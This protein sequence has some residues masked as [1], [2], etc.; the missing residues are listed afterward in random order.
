V[1]SLIGRRGSCRA[2]RRGR[3][4]GV[5]AAAVQ[6]I[7]AASLTLALTA[8]SDPLEFADWTF[9][10][11]EG[12]RVIGYAATPDDERTERIDLVEDLVLGLDDSDPEQRFY[13]LRDVDADGDGNLW[14]LDGGNSR[15]QVFDRDGAFV[16]TV[17]REGQGPG[18]LESP[19]WLT[20]AGEHV[21]VRS[22]QSRISVFSAL[23]GSHVG[24]ATVSESGFSLSTLTGRSDGTFYAGTTEFDRSGDT[25]LS[26]GEVPAELIVARFNQDAG[27]LNEVVRLPSVVIFVSSAAEKRPAGVARPFASFA[28]A[29]TG[30]VYGITASQ[31]QVIALDADAEPAWALR[32]A[33]EPA[34]LSEE[35]IEGAVESARTRR[36]DTTRADLLWPDRLPALS[37]VAVDGHGHIYVYPHFERGEELED[38]PVDVYS[39]DGELLFSGMILDRQWRRARGD[40]VYAAGSDRVTGELLVWRWRLDEPF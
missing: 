19:S 9:D 18:E 23:D 2:D 27:M 13:G 7:F 36:P 34:E 20:V 30:E 39:P 3:P 22:A 11:P 10:V 17:G 40:Y 8:C 35:I 33:Y 24:D 1:R 21:I 32:V 14:V 37:H 26:V 4:I 6:C 38:R 5:V 31:Y 28:A 12:V 16:R 15:I 25:P 29:R